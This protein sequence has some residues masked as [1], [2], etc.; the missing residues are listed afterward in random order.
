MIKGVLARKIWQ[1]PD[2]T[3][4]FQIAKNRDLKPIVIAKWQKRPRK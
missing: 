2:E 3:I 1:D 4:F